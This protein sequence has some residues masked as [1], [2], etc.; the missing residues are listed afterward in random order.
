MSHV[1]LLPNQ[2]FEEIFSITKPFVITNSPPPQLSSI[3]II[4]SL[5]PWWQPLSVGVYSCLS[6]HFLY[7]HFLLLFLMGKACLLVALSFFLICLVLLR[8]LESDYPNYCNKALSQKQFSINICCTIIMNKYQ[9]FELYHRVTWYLLFCGVI[10]SIYSLRQRSQKCSIKR[11]NFWISPSKKTLLLM[12]R[13]LEL[14]WFNIR[15]KTKWFGANGVSIVSGYKCVNG[16]LL[17]IISISNGTVCISSYLSLLFCKSFFSKSF[18]VPTRR[19]KKP[20]CQGAN[21]RFKYHLT[22]KLFMKFWEPL[23]TKIF[24]I[25]TYYIVRTS[26]SAN[27]TP[28]TSDKRF[29]W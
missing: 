17:I 16:L 22:F 25:V 13:S 18:T 12:D 7:F 5:L 26:A 4:F 8:L 11:L 10:L 24:T 27:K 3:H 28:K 29:T 14:E 23:W 15:A 6:I 1:K 9:I 20:P 2:N 21:G 19:L